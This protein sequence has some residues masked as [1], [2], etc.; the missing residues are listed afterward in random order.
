LPSGS[1]GLALYIGLFAASSGQAQI[2]LRPAEP[3]E[4]VNL[5][6]SDQAALEAE[7]G[8]RDIP[9]TV[10]ERKPE[11]GFDLR[12]HSGY[13]VNVPLRELSGNDLLTVLFRVYPEGDRAHA[14]YFVQHFHLPDIEEDAKGDAFLQGVVDVG[15]GRYHFDWL[16]RDRSERICSSGWDVAAQFGSREKPIPLFIKPNNVS[17]SPVTAFF[18][19]TS[20]R[21]GKPVGQG[22][23]VKVLVNF[24]PQLRGSAALKRSDVDALVTILKSIQRDPH[25]NRISLVAFNMDETRVV[26]RQDAAEQIDFPA[27]GKA[28]DSMKLGTVAVGNLGDKY[29]TTNFLEQLIQTEMKAAPHPDAVIFAG[30]K[31][32]LDADVPQ[33]DL[34]RIGDVECPVFYLNYNLNPQAVPWKDSISHAIRVFK[35]TEYTISRPRD[36]WFST[37]E[38]VDRILRWKHDASSTVRTSTG[39]LNTPQAFH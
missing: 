9:C 8:R 24:A 12:F 10:T 26:Y 15:E 27:V 39:R 6:P 11:L 7:S 38:V 35:G 14:S 19:E 18:N 1:A 13:D 34:R 3:G 29:R 30:P 37:T 21:A 20:E 4:V 5:M 25:I 22:L 32:M 2:A 23:N 16:M 36:L 28:L 17:E 33:E 31:A